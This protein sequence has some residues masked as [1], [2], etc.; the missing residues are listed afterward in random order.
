[1]KRPNLLACIGLILVI[2]GLLLPIKFMPIVFAFGFALI[3]S[4]YC[5]IDD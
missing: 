4:I 3:G 2:I 1:M 5:A